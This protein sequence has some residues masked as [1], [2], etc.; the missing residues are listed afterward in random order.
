M[1][2]NFAMNFNTTRGGSTTQV[3]YDA[4]SESGL[5]A[6]FKD[7][8]IGYL[9]IDAFDRYTATAQKDDV[10]PLSFLKGKEVTPEM[11]KDLAGI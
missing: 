9:S 4:Q 8:T 10:I 11:L 1:C 7:G 5:F 6:L 2:V 3:S